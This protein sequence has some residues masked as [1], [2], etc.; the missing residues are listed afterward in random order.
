MSFQVK[1]PKTTQEMMDELL[2]KKETRIKNMKMLS[3]NAQHAKEDAHNQ[4]V[5]E[6]VQVEQQSSDDAAARINAIRE[7]RTRARVVEETTLGKLSMLEQVKQTT[8]NKVLFEMVYDAYWLDDSIKET[9]IQESYDVYKDMIGVVESVCG[10]SKVA[11]TQKTKFITAMEA[12]ISEVCEKAVSR[13]LLEA[14]ETGD[15]EINFNLAPEEESELDTKLAELG[16]DDIVELVRDK[17]L[18]VVQDE[19][20]SGKEK[21]RLLQEI[22]DS[23][24]DDAE[25]EETGEGE[26]DI[27]ESVIPSVK[28]NDPVGVEEGAGAVVLTAAMLGVVIAGVAISVKDKIS[29]K[30]ALKIYEKNCK[31]AVKMSEL[32]PTLYALDRA[33]RVTNKE[34]SGVAKFFNKNSRR[35]KVWKTD[36]GQ[37]ICTAILYTTTEVGAGANISGDGVSP[38]ITTTTT[39][40]YLYDVNPKYKKDQLY[41]S[42]M[43]AFHDGCSTKNTVA[44]AE[45]MKK[46]FPDEMKNTKVK[47]IGKSLESANLSPETTLGEDIEVIIEGETDPIIMKYISD[48]FVERDSALS[49]VY[50]CGVG[51]AEMEYMYLSA[52]E[53]ASS[54]DAVDLLQDYEHRLER[55]KVDVRLSDASKYSH[56]VKTAVISA[57]DQ[58]KKECDDKLDELAVKAAAPTILDSSQIWNGMKRDAQR[59]SLVKSNGKTLF[60]SMM[61]ANSVKVQNNAVMESV[62][63]QKDQIANAALI[64]SVLQYTVLETLNTLQLYNFTSADVTKLRLKN[65]ASVR[66]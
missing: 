65:K 42:A 37:V 15:P 20:E 51:G 9:K 58:Q 16:R 24:E 48:K 35:A 41:L 19:K 30:K 6:S 14:K 43:M 59:R 11:E 44:F 50:E 32:H 47:L 53:N 63:L 54:M 49:L 23:T 1:R 18:T 22:N 57:I 8:F 38:T 4:A 26:D 33:D 2:K 13:I 17:V 61:M 29:L 64:E 40:H 39:Y 3:E 5:L 56:E 31:P 46:A 45:D 12:V 60:E 25:S 34:L 52:M 21:A 28:N 7:K 62:S 36:K 10:T 66:K 27:S 55:A